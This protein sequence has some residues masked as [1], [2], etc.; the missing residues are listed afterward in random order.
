MNLLIE[1][2]CQVLSIINERHSIMKFPNTGVKRDS[3]TCREKKTR[4]HTKDW[5]SEWHYNAQYQRWMLEDTRKGF[6]NSE[7]K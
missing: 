1:N 2:A 3:K 5:E 4:S 7:G 6:Q